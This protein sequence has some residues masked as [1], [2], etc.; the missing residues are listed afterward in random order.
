MGRLVIMYPNWACQ[1]IAN[2]PAMDRATRNHFQTTVVQ[3]RKPGRP[4][5][6]VPS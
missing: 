2:Q 5:A 4:P 6:A 3:N 1:T